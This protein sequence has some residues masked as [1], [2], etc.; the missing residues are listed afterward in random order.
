MSAA[1]D[2]TEASYSLDGTIYRVMAISTPG[3][4]VTLAAPEWHWCHSGYGESSAFGLDG[5]LRGKLAEHKVRAGDRANLARCLN[6]VFR[7]HLGLDAS[8]AG[9]P[10]KGASRG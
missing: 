2:V 8:S 1:N 5:Y 10:A 6:S 9:A 7:K 3:G 4:G